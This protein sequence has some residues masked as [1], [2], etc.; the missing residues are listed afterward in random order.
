MLYR[1][2]VDTDNM[3]QLWEL[4]SEF[5]EIYKKHGVDIVGFW[6]NAE[7]PTEAF[8]ISR[9][10][11]ED[12]YKKTVEKLRSDEQ[13]AKLTDEFSKFRVENQ[14]TRMNPKWIPEVVCP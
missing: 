7:D 2:K 5:E 3:D 12:D 9:Y 8:Y 14:Q 6:E 11:N 10:E 13:Y 1:S 4:R